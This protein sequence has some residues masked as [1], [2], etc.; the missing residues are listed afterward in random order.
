MIEFTPLQSQESYYNSKVGVV[1]EEHI[2]LLQEA[3]D[4]AK[5]PRGFPEEFSE[6][7]IRLE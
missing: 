4:R 5:V 1:K 3:F 7:Y 6:S 2:Q